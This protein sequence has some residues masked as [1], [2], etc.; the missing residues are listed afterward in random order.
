TTEFLEET[1]HT[2]KGGVPR[3][4]R[5]T[6]GA[7]GGRVKSSEASAAATVGRYRNG[8]KGNGQSPFPFSS[9]KRS[10]KA[11][12]LMTN[13]LTFLPPAASMSPLGGGAARGSA[14]GSAGTRGS[15]LREASGPLGSV[16]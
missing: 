14:R 13:A 1:R 10:G 15:G 12:S 3:W 8:E 4:E 2:G 16:D 5:R 11:A 6:R 9:H 7:Q